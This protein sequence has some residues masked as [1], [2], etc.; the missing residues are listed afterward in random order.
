MYVAPHT[1]VAFEG[2]ITNREMNG[3]INIFRNLEITVK[4]DTGHLKHLKL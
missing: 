3:I 4:K 2:E 1:H